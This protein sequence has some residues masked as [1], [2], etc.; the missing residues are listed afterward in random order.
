MAVS[1]PA[2]AAAALRYNGQ[3]YVYGGTGARPGDWDCSSFFSFVVGHDLGMTLP[4]GTWAQVTANGTVH[5]PVVLTYS[6]WG[7][8][9]NVPAASMAP[10]DMVCWPGLGTGGHMGIVTGYNQMISALDSTQG[11]LVTPIDG[12]GPSGITPVFRRLTGVPGSPMPGLVQSSAGGWGT[13]IV[14]LLAGAGIGVAAIVLTLGAAAAAAAGV[15]W[16]A[17]RAAREAL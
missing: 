3:G 15:V 4:G 14:A 1:G 9:V 6:T 11:T 13:M 17:S 5:G 12:Y 7:G 8:A 16:L 2:I 10:G